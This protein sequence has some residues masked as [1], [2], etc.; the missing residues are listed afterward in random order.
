MEKQV[1]IINGK[2]GVGK[3]TICDLAAQHFA[4]RNVSSIT[5]I[6]TMAKAGGWTG[7]KSLAAR[8]MLADLK[9]VMVEY[10]DLPFTYCMEEYAK[11][12]ASDAQILFIHVREPA[13][14]ARL[15]TEIG[16][17]CHTLLIR[18]DALDQK[19]YGNAADDNV[20][21]FSYS[22]TFYN[23][24]PLAQLPDKVHA[25]FAAQAESL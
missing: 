17:N 22:H 4:V 12:C 13:E 5:P 15:Q 8:K 19:Q 24:V 9:A 21:N 2:G 16:K 6:L 18:R 20:Q 7:G 25:F 23:D 3:D 1:Y 11:F 10:N 14:I